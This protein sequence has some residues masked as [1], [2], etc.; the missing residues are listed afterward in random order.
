MCCCF[1]VIFEITIPFHLVA[2]TCFFHVSFQVTWIWKFIFT[3]WAVIRFFPRVNSFVFWQMSATCKKF[4]TLA[5]RILFFPVW[6]WR[7]NFNF[8]QLSK[9]ISHLAHQYGFSP[10]WIRS[11]YLRPLEREN[12]SLQSKHVLNLCLIS[13]N[14]NCSWDLKFLLHLEQKKVLLMQICLDHNFEVA[15]LFPCFR[16]W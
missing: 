13:W 11:W 14:A 1:L 12:S 8:S 15:M 9:P 7:C 16:I 4:T 2:F 3:F 6:V 10:L 5:A